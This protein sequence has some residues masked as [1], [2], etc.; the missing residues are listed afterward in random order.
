MQPPEQGGFFYAVRPNMIVRKTFAVKDATLEDNRISGA[1]SVTG[2]MDLA[3]DVI[4][5]GAFKK[6]LPS[7][8]KSGFVAV[9]HDWDDLPIAMPVEAREVGNQLQTV[10]EFHSTQAA[11]DARAVCVE[12]RS[13]GLDVGLSVGFM[14][15]YDGTTEPYAWFE[16]GAK[17]LQFAK[18]NG[19]DTS[20]F[21]TKSIKAY[22]GFCRAI[23][24]INPL[25]EY[26]ITPIPCN[27][28]AQ[29][30][31]AKSG[32]PGRID[33]SEIESVR[34]FERFLRDA[35]F[36]RSQAV[37]IT[38]HGFKTLQRDA[39][40]DD[41]PTPAAPIEEAPAADEP[42]AESAPQIEAVNPLTLR[43]LALRAERL[44]SS[45]SA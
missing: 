26:S 3:G 1:A 31:D 41:D 15:D 20:L 29:V 12:R 18:D 8:L 10:A 38:L 25:I 11:Q 22:D 23:L 34:D 30:T 32:V 42:A 14:L 33:V 44:R 4:F 27:P 13:R 7:F 43:A 2:V 24:Q 21:D 9:G 19:Y 16:N 6:A 39:D 36:S 28:Q 40:E 17:L 35:G 37:A 5:P 45:I